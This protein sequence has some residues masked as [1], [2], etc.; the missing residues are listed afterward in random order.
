[1]RL[2]LICIQAVSCMLFTRHLQKAEKFLAH[3]HIDEAYVA[4]FLA[5]QCTDRND[6]Q[7]VKGLFS[8]WEVLDRAAREQGSNN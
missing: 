1:M 3:S 2:F 7:K 4:L 5:F 6:A 8:Q